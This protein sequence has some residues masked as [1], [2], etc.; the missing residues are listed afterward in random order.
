MA[1]NLQVGWEQGVAIQEE[2]FM[3]ERTAYI[4]ANLREHGACIWW[5]AS[6]FCMAGVQNTKDIENSTER[7]KI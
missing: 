1:K 5:T 2:L 3:A 7:A 6:D 4:K